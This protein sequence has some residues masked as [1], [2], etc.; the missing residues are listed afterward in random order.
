MADTTRLAYTNRPIAPQ[1]LPSK[2][3]DGDREPPHMTIYD[4]EVDQTIELGTKLEYS[5]GRRFRYTKNGGVVLTKAYMT[6][7]QVVDTNTGEIAQTNL[8]AHAISAKIIRVLVST[9]STF[10]RHEFAGGHLVV[11]AGTGIGDIYKIIGSEYED[12]THVHILLE[13]DGIRTATVATSDFSIHPNKFFEVVVFPTTKTGPCTGVPL[14]AVAINAFF[15]SQTGGPCPIIVDTD[16]DSGEEPVIG[17]DFGAPTKTTHDVPG[18][19]G[20][21]VTLLQNWGNVLLI[22]DVAEPALIWLT[23]DK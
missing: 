21:R 7:A 12:T 5:D 2:V 18:A 8:G 16:E 19:G 13:G 6:S 23:L 14:V 15:W 3:I 11:N 22:G 20:N 10:Q 1:G 4:T 17:N 9:G